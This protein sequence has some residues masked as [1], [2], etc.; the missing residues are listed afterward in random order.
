MNLNGNIITD[1]CKVL[2]CG[3][4]KAVSTKFLLL[5]IQNVSCGLRFSIIGKEHS[6][7]KHFSCVVLVTNIVYYFKV[8][9]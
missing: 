6:L 3:N 1:N 9:A 4:E 2:M 7:K 8:V 5:T